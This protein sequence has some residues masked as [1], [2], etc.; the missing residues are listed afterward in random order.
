[1]YRLGAT[2]SR[3]SVSLRRSL[4]LGARLAKQRHP[5]FSVE[6]TCHT[7]RVGSSLVTT[8]GQVSAAIAAL[9]AC[10]ALV[11]GWLATK[12]GR[13]A[14]AEAV[15]ARREVARERKRLRLERIAVMN[16]EIFFRARDNTPDV[17]QISDPLREQLNKMRH[18][19]VGL[20][21]ELPIVC[22]VPE[23][24][25]R[26]GVVGASGNARLEITNAIAA[27]DADGVGAVS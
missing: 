8:L 4:F 2:S 24:I 6:L 21:T 3:D 15:T 27:L 5:K 25:S 17:E 13:K 11:F 1:M 22:S 9:A 23:A 20:Q 14:V 18:L 16:E 26:T 19:V 10:V 7:S 12:E